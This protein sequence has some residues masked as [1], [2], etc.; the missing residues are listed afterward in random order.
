M[1]IMRRIDCDIVVVGAGPAGSLAAMTAA[2]RGAHAILLEEHSAIGSPVSCA[3]GLSLRGIKD[4]GI[5]PVVPYVCQKIDCA[6]IITPNKKRIEMSS[7]EWVGF[8]LDRSQFDKALGDNAV[9][10]GAEL[11]TN[12]SAQGVIRES[13]RV[14]GVKATQ[15]GE[16]VEVRAQV[17][18]GADGYQS[19]F[20]HCKQINVSAGNIVK[21]GDVI[22]LSG[23]GA[24]DKGHGRS[25]GPHFYFAVSLNGTKIDPATVVDKKYV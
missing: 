6:H 18:I 15:K 21:Q 2:K 5:E 9:K 10:A 23:G 4:A 20:C 14:V 25:T 13:D 7:N 19:I 12:T 3:E 11:M 1:I 16:P 24:N 17:T 22:G 8:N